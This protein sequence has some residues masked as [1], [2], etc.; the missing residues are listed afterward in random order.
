MGRTLNS[1]HGKKIIM[2]GIALG[3]L[4]AMIGIAAFG[5]DG[6]DDLPDFEKEKNTI[7]PNPWIEEDYFKIPMP[8]GFNFL[9]NIGRSLFEMAWYRKDLGKRAGKAPFPT[10]SSKASAEKRPR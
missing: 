8:L 7:I 4:Q 6:W 5:D 9:P 2:G 10:P 1:K 3:I